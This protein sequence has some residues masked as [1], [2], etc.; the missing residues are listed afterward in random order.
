MK[1]CPQCRKTY[2][3][4]NLNFCL[5][6]GSVLSVA[7][8]QPL[9]PETI[10]MNEPPVTQP[11]AP[12]SQPGSQPGWQQPQQRPLQQQQYSMQPPKKSSK[13]WMWVVGILALVFLLC[14]GGLVA[15]LFYIGSQADKIASLANT[16]I[17]R[18]MSPTP[19]TNRSSTTTSTSAR[20]DLTTV[21][22]NMFVKEFSVYGTTEMNGDELTMGSIK[23][24]F[25]YVLVAPDQYTTEASD[26]RVTVRNINDA[27]SSLGYGLIF[28]SNPQPLQQDYAFL[29]DT[30]R[31]KFEVVHHEPQKESIVV[32]WTGSPAINGGT[33]DNMLEVRDQ[34][35]KIEMYINGT[36]VT[37]ITNIY[38]YAGGVVGLYSGDGV[39]IA[40]KDL[41]IRR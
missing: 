37:S 39:K 30:K 4:D 8:A 35:D 5:E 11:Q 31:K 40:F 14:G 6:D 3:D 22:L 1:I 2:A 32:K 10:I 21:D 25:Y 17:E 20:T 33:A 18:S 23:K 24:G 13:T 7:P 36:M 28:H 9:M 38:G 34:P 27:N 12:P 15:A 29:I 41:E 26:T 19:S 16:T